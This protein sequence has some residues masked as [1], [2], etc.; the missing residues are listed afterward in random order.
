MIIPYIG[1]VLLLPV[2]VFKRSYSIYYL[3]QYGPPYDV[4]SPHSVRQIARIG[5]PMRRPGD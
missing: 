4:F 1:T 5:N 3:A 2:A